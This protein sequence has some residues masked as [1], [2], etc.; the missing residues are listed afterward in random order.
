MGLDGATTFGHHNSRI[1]PA[2]PY[3]QENPQKHPECRAITPPLPFC[4][5]GC[6]ATLL[7]VLHLWLA[8]IYLSVWQVLLCC[9]ASFFATRLAPRGTGVLLCVPVEWGCVVYTYTV[10]SCA[11]WG[12]AV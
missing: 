3:G 10:E 5:V 11:V 12:S 6:G 2:P 7:V 1:N 4:G 8:S 9:Y